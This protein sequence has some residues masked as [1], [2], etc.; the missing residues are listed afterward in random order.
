MTDAT[1]ETDSSVSLHSV[2]RTTA[3]SFHVKNPEK[4]NCNG[5]SGF[6]SDA[7][8]TVVGVVIE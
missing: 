4:P 6:I 8:F 1:T 2:A 5:L 3:L 7:Y